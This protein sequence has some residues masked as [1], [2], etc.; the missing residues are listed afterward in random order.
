[1]GGSAGVCQGHESPP[2][3]AGPVGEG[4]V[5]PVHR[6]RHAHTDTH[7]SFSAVS[8]CRVSIRVTA[9]AVCHGG[10][11]HPS[12]R[13]PL[14][15][16]M[17]PLPPCL[18]CPPPPPRASGPLPPSLGLL[19]N[20]SVCANVHTTSYSSRRTFSFASNGS[21]P[22]SPFVRCLSP[23]C[24]SLSSLCIPSSK[25]LSLPPK[26][27]PPSN[28]IPPYTTHDPPPPP[29]RPRFPWCSSAVV[30]ASLPQPLACQV[31]RSGRW[32][33]VIHNVYLLPRSRHA[34]IS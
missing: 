15:P 24:P 28:A 12:M 20:A 14:P 3:P 33:S 25:P 9:A 34:F 13:T 11:A 7:N 18:G 8:L 21:L 6:I 23:L 26:P 2:C 17:P 4:L 27:L 29:G 1:M 10:A 32:C 16:A 30:T 22:R 19:S 5:S 31:S